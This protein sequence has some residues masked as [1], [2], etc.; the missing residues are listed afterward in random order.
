MTATA[1]ARRA[2]VAQHRMPEYDRERGSQ[3]VLEVIDHLLSTGWQVTYLTLNPPSEQRYTRHLARL[4]VPTLIGVGDDVR[5]EIARLEPQLAVIAFWHVAEQLMPIVREASPGTRIVVDSIDLHFVRNARRRADEITT[6]MPWLDEAS[7]AELRREVN[8]YAAA[9]AVLTVS[10]AEAATLT[11]LGG[12]A[13]VVRSVPL[14]ERIQRSD[15]PAKERSGIVFVGN[16]RH[17]P[18]I[19]AVGYLCQEVL[20]RLDPAL[21][22]AHPLTIVGN[23]LDDRVRAAARLPG[24]RLLGWVPDIV[25]YL[26]RA[27]V[28]VSPLLH[29]A[30]VKGKVLQAL[31]AGTP[32]VVTPLSIEGTSLRDSEHLL[33]GD[34][35]ASFARALASVLTDDD[36]WR[37]LADAGY[38]AT[39]EAHTMDPARAQFAAAIADV[40]AAPARDEGAS[41]RRWTQSYQRV[42]AAV[43]LVLASDVLDGATVVV[44]SG[45][46]GNLLDSPVARR[47]AHFPAD[48]DGQHSFHPVD[49]AAAVAMLESDRARGVTHLIVPSAAFWWLHHYPA[50]ADHLR[51]R[52]HLIADHDEVRVWAAKP[53]GQRG[54]VLV[55]ASSASSHQHHLEV[56]DDLPAS[57]L[58]RY[59]RVVMARGRRLEATWLDRF[60]DRHARLGLDVAQAAAM[61][62]VGGVP[63][64]A[65]QQP[66][67][68]AR[69]TRAVTSALPLALGRRTLHLLRR[70]LDLL[71]GDITDLRMGIIDDCST[72]L[73]CPEGEVITASSD[74]VDAWSVLDVSTDGLR[75]QGVP[76]TNRSPRLSVVIATYQRAELL[77]QCLRSLVD[78]TLTTE[79]WE[80]VVVDDGSTDATPEVIRRFVS[81]LPLRWVRIGH[82]GRS[83]AKNIGI[84]AAAGDVV[85]LLDD[86][87]V[88]ARDLLLEHVKAHD[89]DPDAN[90]AVLGYTEWAPGVQITPLM[91]FVTE[92]ATMLFSYHE[93]A[94]GDRVGWRYFWEGRLSC[95]RALL[96]EHGLHDTRLEYTIDIEL[97]YRL[98]NDPGLTVVHRRSAVSYMARNFTYHEF[99]ARAEAKGRAQYQFATLHPDPEVRAYC[100]IDVA[101]RDWAAAEP[102][103][104]RDRIRIAELEPLVDGQPELLDELHQLY[105]RTLRGANRRAI[106][107]AAADEPQVPVLSVVIPV[108]S[109]TPELAEMAARTIERLWEVASLPTE[110]IVI[111]NGSP[112][113]VAMDA[114][115]LIENDRN[116]GVAA[117]WN[118]GI[119][120]ARGATIAVLNSDV[121][122]EPGWDVALHAAAN[123]GRRIVFPHTDHAD[124]LGPRRADQAGTAG[125]C[126]VATREL[127]DEIGTFDESFYPAFFEDADYW[128]R[129][130]NAGVDLTPVPSAIVRHSRRSSARHHPEMDLLFRAHRMK[131][132]W[133]Y[134][135]DPTAPPPYWHRPIV[136]YGI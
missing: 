1:P 30:G 82:A 98:A 52:W 132:S 35:A 101:E 107:Q 119:A 122:V 57:G 84:L 22:A 99:L 111:D 123:D 27:R 62:S 94:D 102:T 60:L 116:E 136:E 81:A 3:R 66:G 126:F 67:I 38:A 69:R 100:H 97:G 16:F 51:D 43:K 54:D 75:W 8:V 47:C 70:G 86:D 89:E 15:L 135:I 124:G 34:T 6:D 55:V 114:S 78:Q 130:F 90:V 39:I 87:D 85:L 112:H 33:V 129:A 80:V 103:F 48:A 11:N 31:M 65:R 24:V 71:R 4:G 88:A 125:W 19:E 56:V 26:Q 68:V 20:P 9:D 83:A 110:V 106:L 76:R 42:Q 29:G 104:E 91:R 127:F 63:P 40:L 37:R 133:K 58:D 23:E 25:P 131:Y 95:K 12:D 49:G 121:H 96:L 93:I 53:Y 45:G 2:L 92:G 32:A 44:V 59:D 64:A 77:E 10:D 36:T 73:A 61:A 5:D 109:V 50:F 18:N 7:V 118:A 79:E 128:T 28:A 13:L 41:G 21:L 14:A 108:W 117:A 115:T 120:A 46:D 105:V 74:P 134:G 17:L 72:P 113:K